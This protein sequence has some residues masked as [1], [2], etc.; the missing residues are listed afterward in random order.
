M[1]MAR[2]SIFGSWH[3]PAEK[4]DKVENAMQSDE[5]QRYALTVHWLEGCCSP[6]QY[7]R[8]ST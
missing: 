7:R 5:G 8:G 4:V 3:R 6:P 2:E 1:A